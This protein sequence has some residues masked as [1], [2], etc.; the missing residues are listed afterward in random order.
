M[1]NKII[2]RPEA[3]FDLKEAFAWYEKQKEGLGKDFLAQIDNSI[4]LIE[5]TPRAC[6]KIFKNVRRYLI[7]RFPCGIFYFIN[8]TEVIVIAIFHVKRNPAIWKSR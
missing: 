1:A 6:Q 2:I 8:I 4:N 5:E 7:H 3:E